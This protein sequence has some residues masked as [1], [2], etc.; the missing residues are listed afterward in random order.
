MEVEEVLMDLI[1]VLDGR[2]VDSTGKLEA[3]DEEE[4]EKEEDEVVVRSG[5]G[6]SGGGGGRTIKLRSRLRRCGVVEF[7]MSEAEHGDPVNG[8]RVRRANS[9]RDTMMFCRC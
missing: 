1:V 7:R 5:D 8:W 6:G 4:E 9:A 3:E 2:A